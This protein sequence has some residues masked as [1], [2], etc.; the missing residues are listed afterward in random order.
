[1]HKIFIYQN[2]F[3]KTIQVFRR[4]ICNT[5][6]KLNGKKLQRVIILRVIEE[7]Y[8]TLNGFTIN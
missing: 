6:E 3:L 4:K 7:D 1:M 5:M 8:Q 2:H